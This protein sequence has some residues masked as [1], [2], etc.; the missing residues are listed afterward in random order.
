LNFGLF[1]VEGKFPGVEKESRGFLN[2]HLTSSISFFVFALWN[3]MAFK[4][5]C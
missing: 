5:H 2:K 1:L 4:D 3:F